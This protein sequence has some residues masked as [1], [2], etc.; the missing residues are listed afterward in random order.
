MDWW[1]RNYS[2]LFRYWMLD[3]EEC[4]PDNSGQSFYFNWFDTDR[5]YFW[6]QQVAK[7]LM[8]FFKIADPVIFS[9]PFTLQ[10]H[11]PKLGGHLLQADD[12]WTHFTNLIKD[13][14]K[15]L[16]RLQNMLHVSIFVESVESVIQHIK[17][18]GRYL[19]QSMG[20]WGGERRNFFPFLSFLLVSE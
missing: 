1:E 2:W 3:R 16:L 18:Q 5:L 9:S 12:C 11:I 4:G 7:T 14:L 13:K 6:H 17:G 20:S 15:P 8:K 10:K 19:W